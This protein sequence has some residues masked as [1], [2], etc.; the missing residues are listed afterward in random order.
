MEEIASKKRMLLDKLFALHRFGIKPGLDRT[1]L[2]SEKVGNPHKLFKLIHVAGTNGKGTVASLIAST[3]KED[4]YVTGLYT[5]PHL[6]DFNERIQINGL[7]IS[8][9]KIIEYLEP[10]IEMAYEIEATFFE[11][12]TIMAFMYFAENSVD[13]AV[14]ETGMGGRFDST[15]IIDS[16][17]AII[18]E[19][20]I[21]HT[22]YLG[23]SIQEIAEEKAGIIKRNKPVLIGCK[24]DKAREI[25]IERANEKNAKI[26]LLNQKSVPR[27]YEL[28]DDFTMMFKINNILFQ[29]PITGE[30]QLVN[31]KI[32][33][34]A[35]KLF[36]PNIDD[37][38][39]IIGFKRL[40]QNT[41]LR[42]RLELVN[43]SPF[44]LIDVAHNP[45][46]VKRL[47]ETIISSG[48]NKEKFIV[49]FA[50]MKD[51][52]YSVILKELSRLTPVI[53]LT[54]PDTMRAADLNVLTKE[55][56]SAGFKIVQTFE[57]SS[58]AFQKIQNND[59][60]YLIC[61]TFFLVG[62]FLKLHKEKNFII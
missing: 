48:I 44:V 25:I 22:E 33:Y 15:N 43:K 28:R 32:A 31:A 57:K 49:I 51:K 23:S 52:D 45:D 26:I 9:E 42:G 46:S 62:E 16:E 27:K 34:D 5:S 59:M 56:F 47:T 40:I 4:G 37:F 1:L 35:I 11:I 8:D 21:D 19:V 39:M 60:K 12:T 41:N 50:I 38:T 7:M 55:A 6:I 30:H 29:A 54:R 20:S 18:T 13:I 36:D 2:L 10:L 61:G 3:L 53:Y 17:L 24:N 58:D 14:I